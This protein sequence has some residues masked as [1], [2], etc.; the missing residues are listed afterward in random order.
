MLGVVFTP[1]W[2]AGQVQT[3]MAITLDSVVVS[4]VAVG[5]TSLVAHTQLNKSDL[6]KSPATMLLPFAIDLTPGVVGISENG[7]GVGNAYLRIR[8]SDAS[9]I[10]VTLNGVPLNDAESQEV[11]WVNLPA[12][13]GFLERVQVQRGVGSSVAGPGAFGGGLHLQTIG[14]SP[15]EYGQVDMAVGSYRTYMTAIGLGIGIRKGFSLDLRYA[16]NQTEGYIR[17]GFAQMH[18]LFA[19]AGYG[20]GRHAF[21]LNWIWGAHV[22]GITWEGV[23][24][25]MMAQDRRANPSGAYF[26][27]GGNLHYYDNETDNYTQNHLQFSW[28]FAPVAG[29]KWSTTMNYTRGD[30][31]YE[32][33]KPD[34]KYASYGLNN[35][36]INGILFSRS[37]VIQRVQMGNHYYVLSSMVDYRYDSW[38]FLSGLTGSVY[39]GA[40]YGDLI[41]AMYNQHIPENYEWYRNH[42]R[43]QEVSL[44]VQSEYDFTGGVTAF[45]DLQY[46][47]INYH[48][49]GPDKDFVLLD[50]DVKYRFFNPKMGVNWHFLT[51][52][53]IHLGF[54]TGHKEPSRSDYKEAVKAGRPNDLLSERMYDWEFGYRYQRPSAQMEMTLY[55]MDYK[56]QLVPTGK[57]TETG[58]VVKEN[59]ASSYRTGV[60]VAAKWQVLHFL[61]LDGNICWSRNRIREYT[62]WVDYY[63]NPDAWG[64]L[65][66]KAEKYRNVSLAY[67]PS[68]TGMALVEATPW[69]ESVVSLKIKYVDKQFYDNTGNDSRALPAYWTGGLRFSQQFNFKGVSE[70]IFSLYVDNLFNRKYIDN[71]WVYRAAFADGSGDYTETGLF[72]QAEINITL[73]LSLKF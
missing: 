48:L 55:Y 33:Y 15:E 44:F 56:D 39:R 52:H 57:L 20:F 70:A 2:L 1:F 34:R 35:Q 47:V 53:Q 14:A 63:D 18:S 36:D 37:D 17:N 73:S 24:P 71:A 29:L 51:C 5:A 45:T 7:T 32:N 8:G 61:R 38:R 41:W 54:F 30:G 72:P 27:A 64:A 43:K 66:Q 26:D 42:S 65:P 21:R 22:T 62:A 10:G 67:S 12:L 28:L 31:F 40:H 23:S 60:E 50:Q 4:A 49:E 46:R 19:R 25:E 6:R 11:F 59:V 3:N 13:T 9:R 69:K 58:Y 16:H 68:C